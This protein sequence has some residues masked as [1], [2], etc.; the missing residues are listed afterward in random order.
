MPTPHQAHQESSRE[1][2][3]RRDKGHHSTSYRTDYPMVAPRQLE[4]YLGEKTENDEG[5]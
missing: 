2:D 4:E 3:S 1:G 5:Q